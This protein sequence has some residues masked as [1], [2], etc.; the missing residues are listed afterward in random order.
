MK[1]GPKTTPEFPPLAGRRTSALSVISLSFLSLF[2]V[3]VLGLI[4]TGLRYEYLSFETFRE[5]ILRPDVL[6]AIQLSIISSLITL[7]LVVIFAVPIGYALSRY[8]FPGHAIVDTITDIPILLPPVVIGLLLLIFFAY[9]PGKQIEDTIEWLTGSTMH[10]LIGIVLCQ[11]LVSIS[12][13][14]RSAKAAFDSVDRR[15]EQVAMSLGCTD[16]QAFHRVTLPLARNGIVAGSIMAWARAV[17]VFGPLVVF[18]GTSVSVRVMPT[19]IYLEL[20]IGKEEVA[21]AVGIVMVAMAS[22]ALA[23]VH[24]LAPGRKWH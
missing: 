5:I 24:W 18:V 13:A 22:V 2:V 15:L 12:Y 20:S 6:A 7:V 3:I 14:I 1:A 17:G 10:S 16:F 4:A 23:I 9:Q 19:L 11:F 21:L 8:R